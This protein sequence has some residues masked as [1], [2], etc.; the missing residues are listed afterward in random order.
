MNE[1]IKLFECVYFRDRCTIKYS[2]DGDG[3][4]VGHA[5]GEEGTFKEL[6]FWAH[7]PKAFQKLDKMW[8]NDAFLKNPP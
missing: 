5:L 1:I 4:N 2:F 7:F 6:D 3:S 8:P